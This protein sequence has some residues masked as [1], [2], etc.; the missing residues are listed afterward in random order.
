MTELTLPLIVVVTGRPSQAERLRSVLAAGHYRVL[1]VS[2]LETAE[3]RIAG[4]GVELVVLCLSPGSRQ[5][6]GGDS[7]AAL[8]RCASGLPA[9]VLVDG[10]AKSFSRSGKLPVIAEGELVSTVRRLLG[11]SSEREGTG[12]IISLQ[13]VKGGVGVSTA[14][15]NLA[16]LLSGRGR[17]LLAEMRLGAGTLQPYFR[18]RRKMRTTADLT[19]I[20]AEAVTAVDLAD[21]LWPCQGISGLSILFAPGSLAV[22]NDWAAHAGRILRLAAGLADYVVVDLP[23]CISGASRAVLRATDYLLLVLERDAM[24]LEAGKRM[25]GGLEAENLLPHSAAA[26]VVSRIPLS[27]PVELAAVERELSLPVIGSIPPA[28]DLCLLAWQSQTAVVNL[29]PEGLLAAGYTALAEALTAALPARLT[30]LRS[31]PG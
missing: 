28:P 18:P 9:V 12:R 16:A 4:G 19:A 13:G 17:A 6:A 3:A 25:L 15:L 8:D 30:V 11:E 21:C 5:A 27:A 7:I 29:D 26:L 10:D 20:P 22:D 24:C 2:D 1:P 31:S 14:A 23:A